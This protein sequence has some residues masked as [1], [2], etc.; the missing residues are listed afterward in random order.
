MAGAHRE[1][2]GSPEQSGSHAGTHGGTRDASPRGRQHILFRS[3]PA[4]RPKL[5]QNR[6]FLT[7]TA[8]RERSQGAGHGA[9]EPRLLLQGRSAMAQ[10]GAHRPP[11]ARC[12]A[13]LAARP[14]TEPAPT[15]GTH[16]AASGWALAPPT[17]QQGPPK[18]RPGPAL[19][20]L[21]PFLECFSQGLQL[22]RRRQA[23]KSRQLLASGVKAKSLE[24]FAECRGLGL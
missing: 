20:L 6:G 8:R 10:P 9:S 12:S 15:G 3:F 24:A 13:R 16:A 17:A 4:L 21:R 23:P 11:P 19:S 14:P 5:V 18:A 1:R 7:A 2:R 22:L